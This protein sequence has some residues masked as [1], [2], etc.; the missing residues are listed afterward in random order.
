MNLKNL[1]FLNFQ[2]NKKKLSIEYIFVSYTKFSV[3]I[4]TT[5]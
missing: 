5:P 4:P 2:S 1:F 3:I